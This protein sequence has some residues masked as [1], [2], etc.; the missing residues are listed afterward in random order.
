MDWFGARATEVRFVFLLVIPESAAGIYLNVLSALARLS[1]DKELSRRLS[2][3]PDAHGIF[4][5]LSEIPLKTNFSKSVTK[6]EYSI[7]STTR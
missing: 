7:P 4:E 6:H 3:S 5:V 1:R 2:G